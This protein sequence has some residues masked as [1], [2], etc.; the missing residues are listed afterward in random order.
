MSLDPRVSV[1][2][3]QLKSGDHSAARK[4]W[5][6][7]YRRLVGLAAARLQGAQRLAADEE[8]VALSA[9][10]SFC[11]GAEQ[12][13]FPQL[14]DRDNLWR[15]LVTLTVRKAQHLLRDQQAQKRGGGAVLGESALLGADSAAP[16]NGLDLVLDREPT[17]EFA[18]EVTEE[19]QRLL[20]RLDNDEMRAIA[21]RK[22]EGDTN[23]EIAARLGCA[24]RTVER[25][26]QLI[27]RIW[28]GETP[29]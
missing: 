7:Y 11:R 29:S 4:L 28:E 16:A 23:E 5:E 10:A 18:A 13:C 27:R 25:R 2:L 3:D 15:L 6:A 22:I 17:P 21:L 12:G 1:W 24:P 14:A 20:E 9:F 8:D 19:C 26:L